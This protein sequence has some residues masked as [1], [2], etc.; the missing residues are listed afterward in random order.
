MILEN[1]NTCALDQSLIIPVAVK[2]IESI[3]RYVEKI[4]ET[5]NNS[6]YVFVEFEPLKLPNELLV[7]SNSRS[8]LLTITKQ[9]WVHVD[10][11]S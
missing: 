6:K 7:W 8:N 11:T 5:H 3:E 2:S 4:I 1:N 9:C 10:Y